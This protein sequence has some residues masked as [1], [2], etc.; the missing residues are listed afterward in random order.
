MNRMKVSDKMRKY[1]EDKI[2][3]QN[4]IKFIK[5]NEDNQTTNKIIIN[6][7]PVSIETTTRVDD[8]RAKFEI[9]D[10]I[11]ESNYTGFEYFPYLYGVL[12]CKDEFL[13]YVFHESFDGNLYEAI[14][15]IEHASEWYS[16]IFQ[17]L[18]INNYIETT[19]YHHTINN[20]MYK[21]NPIQ[22]EYEI[23]GYIFSIRHKY[24]IVLWNLTLMETSPDNADMILDF[25]SS[26]EFKIPAS[27]RIIKMLQEIKANPKEIWKILDQYYNL[28]K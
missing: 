1:L 10:F 16:I 25:I 12:E 23:E 5:E 6:S 17:L 14:E 15:N 4:V 11:T 19:S 20:F 7:I 8:L 18:L 24:L 3:C 9:Y 28:K 2:N 13:L 22:Q 27:F 21:K 26:R